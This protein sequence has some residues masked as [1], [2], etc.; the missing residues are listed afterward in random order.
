M[1]VSHNLEKRLHRVT[2]AVRLSARVFRHLKYPPKPADRLALA[3]EL[4][5]RVYTPAGITAGATPACADP[6]SA[7]RARNRK[8]RRRVHST[9][10]R[11]I[12][13]VRRYRI[14]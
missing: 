5:N 9:N 12:R 6:R 14:R 8:C 1:M 7:S 10:G 2:Y 13:P 4:V 11:H 3:A